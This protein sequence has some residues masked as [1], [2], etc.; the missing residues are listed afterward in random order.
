MADGMARVGRFTRDGLKTGT[1]SKLA[2]YELIECDGLAGVWYGKVDLR[3]QNERLSFALVA[4]RNSLHDLASFALCSVGKCSNTIPSSRSSNRGR[5]S[6][7]EIQETIAVLVSV[8]LG[9]QRL[10]QAY[11][12]S[13]STRVLPVVE[14]NGMKPSGTGLLQEK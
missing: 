7:I 12:L 6:E 13:A 3:K 4:N 11:I 1:S 9:L 10:R 2:G 14:K 5:S 8:L